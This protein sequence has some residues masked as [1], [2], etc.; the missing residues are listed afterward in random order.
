MRFL[1]PNC[2]PEL[3]Q[4]PPQHFLGGPQLPQAPPRSSNKPNHR[5]LSGPTSSCT[6]PR[7]RA[8]P[9]PAPELSQVLPLGPHRPCTQALL[10]STQG[11]CQAP[12]SCSTSP[13]TRAP[14]GPSRLSPL[15][16]ALPQ[17]PPSRAVL[18][19]DPG[20]LSS[21]LSPEKRSSRCRGRRG[22]RE[23]SGLA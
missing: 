23:A 9:D 19:P 3:F 15:G 4:A 17:T 6:T 22:R 8:L 1:L 16:S 14:P 5:T 18:L 21:P 7:T 11:F 20:N 10:G 2:N 13:R 12:L